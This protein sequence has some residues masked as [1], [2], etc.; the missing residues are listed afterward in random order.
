[1]SFQVGEIRLGLTHKKLLI[2]TTFFDM[3][4]ALGGNHKKS[5]PVHV[6]RALLQVRCPL[7]LVE[8]KFVS[9]I[10]KTK[11]RWV[12][13]INEATLPFMS[14]T[15]LSQLLMWVYCGSIEVGRFQ[16]S[17]LLDVCACAVALSLAEVVWTCEHRVREILNI[18]SVHVILKGSE[19]RGLEGVKNF[20]LEYAFGHWNEFIGNTEGAKIL[21]LELFQD[22]SA[23]F[24]NLKGDKVSHPEGKQP[25]NTIMSDYRRL[26]DEMP[27]ADMQI[28]VNGTKLNCHRAVLGM[29]SDGLAA[30]FKTHLKR[31][32]FHFVAIRWCCSFCCSPPCL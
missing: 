24:A 28:D 7:F 15:V 11:P 23:R 20:A 5:A 4:I 9:R 29:Y 10:D 1:M 12:A 26:Y 18:D 31:Y 17:T 3:E 8:G 2:D 22:V 19:D 25:S 30:R 27:H 21:G 32:L 6:H 14:P 13:I 16:L